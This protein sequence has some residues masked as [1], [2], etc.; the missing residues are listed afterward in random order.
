M[1]EHKERYTA[2]RQRFTLEMIDGDFPY[3][4]WDEEKKHI[5]AASPLGDDVLF[6]MRALN[7]FT[8]L[9]GVPSIGTA[10]EEVKK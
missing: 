9:I 3:G 5:I 8:S 7:H 2:E 4:I 1:A 10:N 6:I